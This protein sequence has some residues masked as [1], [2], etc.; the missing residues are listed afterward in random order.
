M[1]RMTEGQAYWFLLR[2]RLRKKIGLN[3]MAFDLMADKTTV[4]YS[5]LF[6]GYMLFAAYREREAS[7]GFLSYVSQLLE[8]RVSLVV[9]T[10]MAVLPIRYVFGSLRSPGI[11]FST[12]E[13]QLSLLPHRLWKIWLYAVGY[14]KMKQLFFY[15]LIAAIVLGLTTIDIQT[16]ALFIGIIFLYDLLMVMPQWKLYQQRLLPKLGWLLAAYLVGAA[17]IYFKGFAVFLPL[18]AVL[19]A[20]VLIMQKLFVNI[21]WGR[22]TEAG[23]FKVWNMALVG[24]ASKV[25]MR[26]QKRYRPLFNRKFQGQ[27]FRTESQMYH[28]LWQLYFRKN[29]EL[30]SRALG[31]LLLMLI[32]MQW[33]PGWLYHL[34]IAAALF[35]LPVF[36]A[37]F[38]KDRLRADLIE[39]LPWNL[40]AFQKTFFRWAGIAGILLFVP[41]A[42]YFLRNWDAWALVEMLYIWTAGMYILQVKLAAAKAEMARKEASL[43]YKDWISSGLVIMAALLHAFPWLA[44]SALPVLLL[45]SRNRQAEWKPRSA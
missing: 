24:T 14:Q 32:L 39:M 10:L 44:F 9:F 33:L 21:Q 29:M 37:V 28:R 42:V 43:Q 35:L 5:L 4:F 40:A 27:P 1:N 8:G 31:M 20:N 22:V 16:A 38:F 19:A 13:Y 26:R 2:N 36:A 30:L 17:A 7:S 11:V 3:K 15:I 41:I 12:S 25:K 6:F 18:I 45:L 34:A 23:D